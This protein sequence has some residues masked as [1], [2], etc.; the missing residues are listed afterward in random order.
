MKRSVQR[1]GGGGT[2]CNNFS[3]QDEISDFSDDDEPMKS[4]AELLSQQFGLENGY[5]QEEEYF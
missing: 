2:Q 3:I 1:K 4:A 5:G